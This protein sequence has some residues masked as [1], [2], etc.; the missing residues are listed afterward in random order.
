MPGVTTREASD[1][2]LP[3]PGGIVETSKIK[4]GVDPVFPTGIPNVKL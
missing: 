3:P 4:V 1:K 2:V